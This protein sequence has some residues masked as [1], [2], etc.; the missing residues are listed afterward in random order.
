MKLGNIQKPSVCAGK[1]KWKNLIVQILQKTG[2]LYTR[3]KEQRPRQEGKNELTVGIEGELKLRNQQKEDNKEET[4]LKLI[5][6]EELKQ[7]EI[8]LKG[9]KKKWEEQEE[10]WGGEIG[11]R[12]ESS[13]TV[14]KGK[15]RRKN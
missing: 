8:T 4:L 6:I 9:L 5:R 2:K 1:E 14:G 11:F 3:D 12:T 10:A 7:G 13:Q 15:T